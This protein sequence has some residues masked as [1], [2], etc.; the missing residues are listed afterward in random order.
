MLS[1]Q[2]PF[3]NIPLEA[4]YLVILALMNKQHPEFPENVDNE[5]CK[6]LML[7]CWAVDPTERP[8][9]RMVHEQLALIRDNL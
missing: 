5:E 6:E 9:A 3:Y 7:R 4:G 1:E 8:S 2:L